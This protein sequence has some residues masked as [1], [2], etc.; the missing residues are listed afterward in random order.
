MTVEEVLRGL[1]SRYAHTRDSRVN[2]FRIRQRRSGRVRAVVLLE[3]DD[4][5]NR[6]T[7]Q[8]VDLALSS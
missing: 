3:I 4:T 7:I 1:T 8:Y 6:R 5:C 2:K